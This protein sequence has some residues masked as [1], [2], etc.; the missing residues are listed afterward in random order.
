MTIN[1]MNRTASTFVLATALCTVAGAAAA[2]GGNSLPAF[3]S[4]DCA[5]PVYPKHSLD[6]REEGAAFIGVLVDA[7]GT[8]LDTKLLMS[9]GSTALDETVLS[10]HQKCAYKP[11]RFEGQPV[12]MWAPMLYIY[13]MRPPGKELVPR[14]AKAALAGDVNARF[15]LG[16]ILEHAAKTNEEMRKAMELQVDAAELGHPI[17]QVTLGAMYEAG[18]RVPKNLDE[19]RY[20]YGQAAAQGNVYAIDHLRF[21]GGAPR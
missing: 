9:S 20:W 6:D 4:P 7:D 18:K 10:R 5:K 1:F 19:A 21:I 2:E 14:L 13:T 15:Q 3:A 16:L 11:G 8:V 12:R 17:A